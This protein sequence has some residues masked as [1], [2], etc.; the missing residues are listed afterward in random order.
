MVL[1]QASSDSRFRRSIPS[2]LVFTQCS[3]GQSYRSHAA[4]SSPHR[5]DAGP[6]KTLSVSTRSR[7]VWDS[8]WS[9]WV[10]F[11]SAQPSRWLIR[12][13]PAGPRSSTEWWERIHQQENLIT[14]YA[15]L[16]IIFTSAAN[17]L[18]CFVLLFRVSL[19][20][21]TVKYVCLCGF[22]SLTWATVIAAH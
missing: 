9:W 6:Q 21:I 2:S 5:V 8:S 7:N 14:A 19:C 22:L 3:C 11:F 17:P 12:S 13:L 4:P 15:A 16:F 18:C 10:S 1:L 20:V